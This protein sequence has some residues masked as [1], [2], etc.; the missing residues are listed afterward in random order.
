MIIV[1]SW[2]HESAAS[3]RAEAFGSFEAICVRQT[4]P[5]V[6]DSQPPPVLWIA[7]CFGRRAYSRLSEIARLG[8]MK[9]KRK[10]GKMLFPVHR[11][12]TVSPSAASK[13]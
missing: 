9:D 1:E 6:R 8:T 13:V 11:K 3:L 10:I 12:A 4:R 7:C 2:S 5:E